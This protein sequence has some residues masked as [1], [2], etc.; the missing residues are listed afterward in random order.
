MNGPQTFAVI[1]SIPADSFKRSRKI[2][3]LHRAFCKTPVS[4][5]RDGGSPK[6]FRDNAGG[7]WLQNLCHTGASIFFCKY[8]FCFHVRLISQPEFSFPAAHYCISLF[9]FRIP[10]KR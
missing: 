2:H 8:K 10:L 1:E 7:A 9:N 6:D 3:L 5:L 4:N